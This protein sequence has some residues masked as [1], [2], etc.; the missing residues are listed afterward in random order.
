MKG[1]AAMS[2]FLGQ[3]PPA[4]LARLKAELAETLIANFCYPRFFDH[5]T[6]SLR[7][8]P[9]D[10]TKRQ[11]VWLYL[12]SIDFTAWNRV[13]LMSSDF[14]RH[15]ERLI[16]YFVQR[17]R[18]FFGQQGRKRM[19]DVRMLISSCALLVAEGMRGHLMGRQP[20]NPPFGS[21][22]PSISWSTTNGSGSPEPS[23][24]Q[25]VSTTMLLQQQLQEVRGEIRA[26][27]APVNEMYATIAISAQQRTKQARKGENGFSPTGVELEAP[28][29]PVEQVSNGKPILQGG[30][31]SVSLS[32]NT[33]SNRPFTLPGISVAASAS[34]IAAPSKPRSDAVVPLVETPTSPTPIVGRSAGTALAPSSVPQQAQPTALPATPAAQPWE[35]AQSPQPP[36]VPLA[37]QTPPRTPAIEVVASPAKNAANEDVVIF[38]RM[39]SK[40]VLWLRIEAVRLGMDIAGQTPLQLLELLRQQKGFDETRLQI[41]STLL[42]LSNQV[43]KNGQASHFDYKQ[44]LIF[45]LMHT[46]H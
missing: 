3:L 46:Q 7:M 11:E 30:V 32:P 1:V 4:E 33:K 22:R 43:I 5:R 13:D 39:Y 35:Y 15:I 2:V 14:Q 41:V 20:G 23:W 37:P 45:Y 25:I 26:G 34:T 38:E 31:H 44:G 19:S 40:L 29:S 24:E 12:S 6:N 27:S 36:Q 9:V 16:I 21:P 42:N 28:L 18:S 10:R 8:R 17:N